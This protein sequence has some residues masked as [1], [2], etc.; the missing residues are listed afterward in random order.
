[1]KAGTSTMRLALG[2][3]SSRSCSRVSLTTFRDTRP[4]PSGQT[5][6]TAASS[7]PASTGT[8]GRAGNTVSRVAVTARS[9]S[10]IGE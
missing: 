2:R 6:V 1:M 5:S 10:I 3:D 8:S 7:A 9:R 4:A